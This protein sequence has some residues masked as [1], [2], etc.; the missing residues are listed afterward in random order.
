MRAPPLLLTH[1]GSLWHCAP[2]RNNVPVRVLPYTG[3]VVPGDQ[4]VPP[5]NA[6]EPSPIPWVVRAHRGH[7]AWSHPA[8]DSARTGHTSS[9]RCRRIT[10]AD[11]PPQK[12]EGGPLLL[13]WGAASLQD[14]LLA[15]RGVD[16][17][18][19]VWVR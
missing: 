10:N 17:E 14:A 18:A 11:A 3:R 8:V 4:S 15:H 6:E 13:L 9:L 5:S 19:S 2:P 12:P 1:V 16:P 7:N